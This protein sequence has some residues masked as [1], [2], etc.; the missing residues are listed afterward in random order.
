MSVAVDPLVVRPSGPELLDRAEVVAIDAIGAI[1]GRASLQRLYGSRGA[2]ELQLAP[3]TTVA[4]A[5]VDSMERQARAR[6]LAQLELDAGHASPSVI[7]ALHHWRDVSD[8]P[9]GRR[10]YLTWPTNPKV[11]S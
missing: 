11:S 5:L 4:L 1:V 8:E 10:I 9:R 7:A 6:G 2:L 3:T